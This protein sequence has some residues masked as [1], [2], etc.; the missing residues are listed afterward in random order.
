M[1]AKQKVKCPKN[2]RLKQSMTEN[3]LQESIKNDSFN[4]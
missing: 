2:W 3:N 4:L 1:K